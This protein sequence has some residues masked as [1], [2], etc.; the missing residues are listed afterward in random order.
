MCAPTG[1]IDIPIA[2]RLWSVRAREISKQ[3]NQ[4]MIVRNLLIILSTG[5]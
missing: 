5:N 4:M 3:E 2:K 1:T